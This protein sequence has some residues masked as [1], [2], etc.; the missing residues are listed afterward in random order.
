MAV[1]RQCIYAIQG[2]KHMANYLNGMGTFL[3]TPLLIMF[4]KSITGIIRAYTFMKVELSRPYKDAQDMKSP[5][6]IR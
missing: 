2:M 3:K 6:G 1:L 5:A 4:N